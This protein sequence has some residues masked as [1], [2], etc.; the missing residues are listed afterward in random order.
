MLICEIA[1][2]STDR[3]RYPQ[4]CTSCYTLD[5]FSSPWHLE[6]GHYAL[7]DWLIF[8]QVDAISSL[9]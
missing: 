6:T 8:L 1:W 9:A 4:M 3:L 7:Q 5:L 2:K